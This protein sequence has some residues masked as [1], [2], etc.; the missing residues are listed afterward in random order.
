MFEMARDHARLSTNFE[1][2][3]GYLSPVNDSY[4]KSGLVSARHR[5][6]MCELACRRSSDW[7]MLDPWEATQPDYTP[8]AAVLDHYKAE[9][10]D[11]RGGIDVVVGEGE[12]RRTEKRQA[13]IVLLAG[14]DLIQTMSEPGLWAEQDVRLVP[15]PLLFFFPLFFFNPSCS[16]F[17]FP[18]QLR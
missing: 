14:S 16:L 11:K 8:T 6:A 17:N 2:V 13:K 7:V 15:L 1:V 3:G 5:V 4:R 12:S 18:F 9:I 10:N